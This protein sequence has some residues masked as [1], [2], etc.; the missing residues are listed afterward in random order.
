MSARRLFIGFDGT[1]DIVTRISI[2]PEYEEG[3]V[4]LPPLFSSPPPLSLFF[5]FLSLSSPY[6]YI[7]LA[8]LDL[9]LSFFLYLS[10]ET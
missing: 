10:G 7:Y 4:P 6:T 5:L 1:R 2:R 9:F 3:A 8:L